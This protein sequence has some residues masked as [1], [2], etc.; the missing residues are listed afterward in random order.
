MAPRNTSIWRDG[1]L[2]TALLSCCLLTAAAHGQASEANP[3]SPLP[4]APAASLSASP[5]ASTSSTAAQTTDAMATPSAPA[6]GPAISLDE[7][8]NRARANA[9]VFAAAVAQAKSAKLDQSIARSALLP[10]AIYHNQFLYTQ[11]GAGF[12]ANSVGRA[13]AQSLGSSLPRFI[14]NN[15]VHEYVSQASVTETIGPQQF[16]AVSKA[17]TALAVATAELEI[18]R[19][20]LVATV[21]GLYYNA[22][23]ADRKVAIAERAATEAASFT[24]LTQQREQ[25]RESAH[26]DVVKAQL[27]QQQRERD[28]ADAL[29]LQEKDRLDLGVLLNP[30]PRSPYALTPADLSAPLPTRADVEAALAKHNPE[31]RSAFASSHLANLNVT[32]ARLGYLPDLGLTYNYGIDAA[33]FAMHNSIG[34][35]NLGYSVIATLDIP[36]WDWFTTHNRVKQAQLARETARVTLNNTQRQLIADLDSFYSEARVAHDQIA[37]LDQSV[38]TATESL[39]LTRLRYTNGE[40]TVLE[41]VDAQ[42][43]LTTA[44][45]AREDGVVRYQTA[46]ANLQLLTGTI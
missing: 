32:S 18:A 39:R 25:A 46:L 6:A 11:G 4:A 17:T 9:P 14:A 20:G 33:Q 45:L 27:L 38:T 2:S 8:I 23:A 34:A 40:A 44:E 7:A 42:S 19:R 3:A 15:A 30:D 35:N 26:A 28:I 37:S 10:T 12:I 43:S 36:L 21:V 16:N 5:A 13:D 41:V 22:L 31:L 29:L 1:A 24:Q